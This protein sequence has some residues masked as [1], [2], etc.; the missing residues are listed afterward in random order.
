MIGARNL[1]EY[2]NV[3]DRVGITNFGR[4]WVCSIFTLSTL[5]NKPH[6]ILGIAKY[7]IYRIIYGIEKK[8]V[9]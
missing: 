2:D 9:T 1:N 3:M 6:I 4:F 5:K 8:W 7:W